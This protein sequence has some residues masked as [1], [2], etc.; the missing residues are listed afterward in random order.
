MNHRQVRGNLAWKN[1]PKVNCILKIFEEK[2]MQLTKFGKKK[3]KSNLHNF[4][5]KLHSE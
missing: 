1:L 2:P 5:K 4:E 3:N